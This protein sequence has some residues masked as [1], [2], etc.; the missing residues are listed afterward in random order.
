MIN[1]YSKNVKTFR[2]K[3]IKKITDMEEC[4]MCDEQETSATENSMETHEKLF[5]SEWKLNIINERSRLEQKG[6]KLLLLTDVE[7]HP[8]ETG[9]DA[10]PKPA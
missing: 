6:K 8:I 1:I 2:K 9:P 10:S 3:I 4:S 7:N 5:I